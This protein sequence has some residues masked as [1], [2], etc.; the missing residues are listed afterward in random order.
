MPGDL[1]YITIDDFR[2]G[3]QHRTFGVGDSTKSPPGAA[4][5]AA[6]FRCRALPWGGLGPLPK[7]VQTRTR[8]LPAAPDD[9][10]VRIS[11]LHVTGPIQTADNTSADTGVDNVELHLAFEWIDGT[12]HK[13]Q[14]RRYHI[15]DSVEAEE[16]IKTFTVTHPGTFGLIYRPTSF[17]DARL[18]AT[19]ATAFG[20]LFVSAGWHPDDMDATENVWLLFPDPA[21]PTVTGTDSILTVNEVTHLVQHQGR[22]VSIDNHV[23]RH[24]GSGYWV[25]NDQL[26]YT[27]VNLPTVEEDPPGTIVGAAVFTQGPVSGYG[28]AAS[29]SAQELLLVKHRGGATTISGDI[30]DPTVFSL[31]GVVSTRGAVTY[32]VWT[33]MGFVYGVKNGGVYAWGGGDTSEKLS[34]QL[35]DNF[36]QMRPADW[37]DFDGKFDIAGELLLCPNN[38]IMDTTDKSWWRIEDPDTYQIFQWAASPQSAH[39]FGSPVSFIEDGAIYYRFDGEQLVSDYVWQSQYIAA[40]IDRVVDIR[41]IRL[42]ALSPNGASEVTVTLSDEEGHTQEEQ[43]T[44]ESTTIPKLLRVPT[45]FK[46]TGI[47]VKLEALTHGDVAPV[48]HELHLGYQQAQREAVH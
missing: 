20:D 25:V 4:D 11:G 38:W 40:T 24:G 47:K 44:V 32:G 12:D 39:F 42:R 27:Q 9:G 28:A 14:W 37:A 3:I 19:D 6:T 13:W 8:D 46:G 5:P 18:H 23:F 43:F 29:A 35:E 1:Q 33:P 17:V 21:A 30:D 45:S 7:L 48:I 34:P 22:I 16:A 36:W 26:I 15:Y 2:P 31:P 10:I 41:E